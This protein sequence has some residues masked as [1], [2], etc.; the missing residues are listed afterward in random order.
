M[1]YKAKYSIGEVSRI[2]KVSKKTLRY[3]DE[4]GLITTQRKDYNNYRYYT[5]ESL[6]TVSVIKYYKQMGFTLDEM[7]HLVESDMPNVYMCIQKSF[8]NKIAQ[9]EKDRESIHR[10]YLSVKNWYDLVQEAEQILENNINE[11][12]VKFV[13][14]SELLYREQEYDGNL[15]AAIINIDFTNYLNELNNEITG[16]VIINFTSLQ[17]R[18]QNTGQL[19]QI[20]QKPLLPSSQDTLVPF[21][22]H[23]MIT[24]YHTGSHDN[25]S[26]TYSKIEHWAKQHGYTLDKGSYERY[27]VDYWTTKDCDKFVTEVM[28]K[29][30][31]PRIN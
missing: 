20:M 9:L 29:A 4:I 1:K 15:M 10:K 24:C 30:C 19:M 31:K 6:Q 14:L 26:K 25:I 22:G 11:V 7:R 5:F 23:T 12:S 3:Y 2:C 18:V 13:E 8:L 28:I 27:V 17:D 16:P 21:G